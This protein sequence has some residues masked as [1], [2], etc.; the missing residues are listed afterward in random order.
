VLSE[1]RPLVKIAA[2][3]IL[4]EIGWMA[5]G[6]VDTIM[7]GPLGPAAIGAT[8]IG[9][10][11]FFA[12]ATFAIG[13]MLGLDAL[14]SQAYGAKRLD[15]C[16]RWLHHG[17]A[18]AVAVTPA[19]MLT[20]WGL[21]LTIDGWGLH[22]DIGAVAGR[23]L[24][25]TTLGTLPLMLYASFRRYLHGLHIVGPMVAALLSA[26][27]VN[28]AGNWVLIY[29]NLGMPALGVDG[30]A[31]AT[32][33]ARVYMA[34][35]ISVAVVRI[36]R[37]R[38]AEHPHVPLHLEAARMRRLLGL[39]GP[40]AA[41]IALEVGAFATA[42]TLA[43]KL[44]PVQSASHQISQNIASLAFMV[45]LGLSSAAAVRVG[46]AVGAGDMRRTITAGW[47]AFATGACLTTVVGVAMLLWR[48]PLL[49]AFTSDARVIATGVPLLVIA[50]AFQVVD[51]AQAVATGMLRGVGDT[52]IPMFM[53]VI[54]H[55]ML[56]LPAGYLLCFA[57]GWGV[58]GLW[59]GL[60]TGLTF[61]AVALTFV[62]A[63]RVRHLAL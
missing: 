6:I 18:L 43:G 27:L 7:V 24:A 60:A 57:L 21:V 15:E 56:G 16:L 20:A 17:L 49:R 41:Q 47:T 28:A 11:L 54:G 13:L 5:M 14:V 38:G 51:G 31:W 39:G 29:G 45:P 19:V 50:A 9:S 46:H 59:F 33:A 35:F 4:G 36:H 63:R 58:R 37:R 40:A 48:E 61:V 32:I 3:I 12:I 55:W 2:P 26:N 62:W 42:A 30:S 52:R 22:P 8:G 44:D 25:I 1:L 34:V 10:S 53:N 23:Y